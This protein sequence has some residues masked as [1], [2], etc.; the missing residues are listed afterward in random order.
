[1]TVFGTHIPVPWQTVT[2]L[3]VSNVFMTVAIFYMVQP[4]KLDHLWAALCILGAV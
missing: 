1:M 4:L 2:L 3:G